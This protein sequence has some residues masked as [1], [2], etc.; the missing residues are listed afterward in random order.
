MSAVPIGDERELSSTSFSALRE[1]T[2]LGEH[3]MRGVVALASLRSMSPWSSGELHVGGSTNCRL[4]TIIGGGIG[5]LE[6]MDGRAQGG[7]SPHRT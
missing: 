2:V 1:L 6:A 3:G 5:G 4:L 7:P